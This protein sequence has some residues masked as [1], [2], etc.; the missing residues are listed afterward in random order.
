MAK[1]TENSGIF[2]LG[3]VRQQKALLKMTESMRSPSNWRSTGLFGE[4][5]RHADRSGINQSEE[6]VAVVGGN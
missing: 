2:N 3:I 6:D 4:V 5:R 1:Q